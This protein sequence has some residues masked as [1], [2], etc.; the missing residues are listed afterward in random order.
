MGVY[1][2][3]LDEDSEEDEYGDG[4]AEGRGR[5]SERHA[6]QAP[7]RLADPQPPQ[8][9]LHAV[10]PRHEV[11]HHAACQ[12]QVRHRSDTSQIPV[13][14]RKMMHWLSAKCWR[15]E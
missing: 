4:G 11:G 8:A 14:Q 1:S 10:A 12:T 9:A 7:K 2:T 13:R 15:S 6:E 5:Q 3:D